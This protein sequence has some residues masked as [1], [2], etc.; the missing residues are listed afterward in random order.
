LTLLGLLL[1]E[2]LMGIPG[3]IL[4]PVVLDFIKNEA[5]TI[6]IPSYA[7]GGRGQAGDPQTHTRAL[8]GDGSRAD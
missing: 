3:M 1:G 4:A 2:R 7:P 5:S 8:A 6:V